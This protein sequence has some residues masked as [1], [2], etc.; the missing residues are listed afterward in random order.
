MIDRWKDDFTL[1]KPQLT[2]TR[3]YDLHFNRIF[4][5]KYP[6]LM[7]VGTVTAR[8]AILFGLESEVIEYKG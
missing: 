2:T 7:H 3:C 1:L 8:L 4:K 5:R 6:K